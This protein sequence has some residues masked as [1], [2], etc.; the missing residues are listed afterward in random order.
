MHRTLDKMASPG[1][2][3][4]NRSSSANKSGCWV[5]QQLWRRQL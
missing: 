5:S 3:V 2:R 4:W 1:Q